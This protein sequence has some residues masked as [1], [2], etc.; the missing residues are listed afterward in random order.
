M[1]IHKATRLL[2]LTGAGISAES[3]LKTFRDGDGLWENHRMEDVA[4]PEAFSRDPQMVWRFYKA[5]REQA[6]K[7]KPNP[8]HYALVELE[9]YLG[10]N[11]NLIT[12]NV[13][14][15]HKVAGNKNPIEMHGSLEACFCTRCT[16]KYPISEIDPQAPVPACPQCAS[17]L[18]PDIVWF[19]E[20]PYQ[21]QEI[22]WLLQNCD[23]FLLVGTSG[24]VFPAAGFVMTAKYL[25]AKTMAVNLDPT[26]NREFIDEFHQ[27]RAGEILPRLVKEWLQRAD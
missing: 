14:C 22:E 16:A 5:R 4:T 15:L 18:R 3:G 23:V 13:D 8:G 25:G 20:L 26:V 12:Q 21:M 10:S 7:A 19:G 24:V 1:I 6:L 27:G 17:A 9:E 2:V 11:F